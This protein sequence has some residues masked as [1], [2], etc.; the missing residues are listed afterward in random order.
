MEQILLAYCLA[1]ANVTPI[2]M[3]YKITKVNGRSPAGDT[4][5]F[6]IIAGVLQGKRAPYLF[7]ISP[8][9]GHHSGIDLMKENCFVLK[10][11]RSRQ[12]PAETNTDEDYTEDKALLLNAPTQAESLLHSL[13]QVAGG[14]GLYVNPDKMEYMG[15]QVLNDKLEPIYNLPVRT[16]YVLKRTCKSDG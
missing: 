16:H 5:F 2:M 11:A 3:F 8:D 9:Y 6:D 13:E 4:D 14:I 15:V 10:N 7:I 12:Y 1:K